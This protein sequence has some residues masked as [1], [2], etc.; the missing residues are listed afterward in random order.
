MEKIIGSNGAGLIKDSNTAG[1]M[2]DVVET[3]RQIPVIVDF[4]APWC[5]PCKTLG[6]ALERAV[7]AAAGK[8]RMVKINVDENQDLAGQLRVQSVPTVFS[9]RDGQPVDGFAGAQP[10]SRI[11][12]FIEKLCAGQGPSP[13][14]QILQTGEEALAAGDHAGAAQAFGQV[15]QADPGHAAALA[16]L[17]QCFIKSG[18]VTRARELIGSLPDELARDT[19]FD[20]VRAALALA[21]KADAAGDPQELRKAVAARP[22]DHQA[23]FDLAVALIGA[24]RPGEAADELLEIIRRERD[25]KEDAARKQLVE[26]FD[27]LGPT[28]P[29][30][31]AV[32]QKLSAL[33]FS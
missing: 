1:F 23:R 26:L 33:L 24:G 17:A 31:V 25:W 27:A 21:E 12:A 6:P 7:R 28:D 18:D 19:A 3:S 22:D 11:K 13:L 10:E 2:A 9:F 14:E 30:T 5:E 16:G 15:L 20:G 32:R 4:W 8:V 29:L